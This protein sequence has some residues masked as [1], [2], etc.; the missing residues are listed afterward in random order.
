MCATFTDDEV[1]KPVE[2]AAG[3]EVGV[4]AT[5]EGDVAHVRPAADAVDSIK[6]SIGWEGVAD[7]THPLASDAV[8]EITDETVRL[9]GALPTVDDEALES[10]T[11]LTAQGD[12][13]AEPETEP[14]GGS[15]GTEETEVADD[16]REETDE[17]T[18]EATDSI[19]ADETNVTDAERTGPTDEERTN[20]GL[21]VDP[22]ELARQEPE[23]E[24]NPDDTSSR[25]DAAVDPTDERQQTDAAVDL[26]GEPRRTDAAVDPGEQPRR[27][28]AEVDPDA[29]DDAGPGSGPTTE[30]AGR[31]EFEDGP[32]E[33]RIDPDATSDAD[34][35][36]EDDDR[37]E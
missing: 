23:A 31:T 7:E 24:F 12:D 2:N 37:T 26:D 10:E 1:G 16:L 13:E 32:E 8:R 25:T 22:T 35:D 18:L 17:D 5:V 3:E 11:D 9:E 34:G 27:T 21:E 6:S 20:R 19:D 4:V 29:I 14:A 15:T 30:D 28:D 36:L 33:R